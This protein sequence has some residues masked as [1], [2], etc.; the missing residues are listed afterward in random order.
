MGLFDKLFGGA[1]ADATPQAAPFDVDAKRRQLE[2]LSSALHALTR[3]MRDDEFPVDNPGWQGRIQDLARSRCEVD[4]LAKAST[5][6]RQDV[7]DLGTS[8]RPLFRGTP[9]DDFA[10]VADLNARLLSAIDALLDHDH[11]GGPR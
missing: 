6:D 10:P 7:F 3:R 1:R 11:P 8:I 9:P 4:A 2:E 5:F